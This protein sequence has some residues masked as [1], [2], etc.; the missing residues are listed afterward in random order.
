MVVAGL[1]WLAPSA[2]AAVSFKVGQFTKATATGA[3]SV[4]TVGFQPK[5]IVFFWADN[6]T[7]TFKTPGTIGVGFASGPTPTS[8]GAITYC[9]EST[10]TGGN[11]DTAVQVSTSTIVILRGNGNT[12]IGCGLVNGQADLTSMDSTGFTLNWTTANSSTSIIRYLA[13]GGTDITNTAVGDFT[14]TSSTGLQSVSSLSFQ[15]D[16]LLLMSGNATTTNINHPQGRFAL[17]F[18]TNVTSTQAGISIFGENNQTTADTVSLATTTDALA[19][20]LNVGGPAAKDGVA[21][22]NSL[23]SN[24][25]TVN[26]PDATTSS[27]RVFYLAIQGGQHKVGNF[28]QATTTGLGAVTGVGFQPVGVLLTSNS[29][30]SATPFAQ[31]NNATISLGAVGSTTASGSAT[32]SFGQIAFT[33]VDADTTPDPDTLSTS[34]RVITLLTPVAGASPTQSAAATVNSFDADGFTM[35]WATTT[36]ATRRVLYWAIGNAVANAAPT[37]ANVILNNSSAITLTENTTTSI[38]VTASSTDTDGFSDMVSATSTIYR[39][40]VGSACTAD[41]NNCYKIASSSCSFSGCSGNTCNLT[42][43][44][45]IYFFADP[46]DIGT[47]SGEDWRGSVTVTDASSET[48]SSSTVSG[49]ELNTLLALNVTG[50]IGYGSISPGTDTDA[51]N[52]TTTVTNTGNAAIDTQLSGSD[53]TSG[54]YTIGVAN[55]IYATSSFTYSSCTVCTSLSTT[56]SAYELDLAKPT[57]TTPVSDDVMWGLLVPGGSGVAT[58]GGTNTFTAV[59]D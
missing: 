5:A 52:Q 36:K 37:V 45:S 24:G 26:K 46:T 32:S 58:Y 41:N 33:D 51:T 22:I 19:Q 12:T 57:S 49:V 30:S 15:P 13:L 17:G 2:H 39:S 27:T 10:N 7:E 38:S 16:I 54:A 53:M 47:F 29:A 9:S 11:S 34:T 43:T 20:Y 4:S 18:S 35:N 1:V 14:M 6:V 40:G 31:Q 25:F 44:A 8:S 42:C 55:Q 50:A 59:S 3:Q 23:N 28:S 21:R 48:G 56:P